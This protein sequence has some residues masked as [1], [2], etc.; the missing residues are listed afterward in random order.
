MTNLNPDMAMPEKPEDRISHAIREGLANKGMTQEM[1]VDRLR[2]SPDT[3]ECLLNGSELRFMPEIY[4]RG[5][6]RQITEELDLD[7]E[8][9]YGLY[10]TAHKTQA[11]DLDSTELAVMPFRTVAVTAGLACVGILAVLVAFLGG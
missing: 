7:T 11:E 2:I 4:V 3:I 8:Q 10:K 9:M 1:L 6:M 5:Y